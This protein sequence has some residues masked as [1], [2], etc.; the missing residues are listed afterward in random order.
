[1][2]RKKRGTKRGSHVHLEPFIE[3][4]EPELEERDRR[5]WPIGKALPMT[6]RKIRREPPPCPKCRR[7]RTDAGGQS[8]AC[9]S[10]GKDR[11]VFRCNLCN[12]RWQL[13]V[14]TVD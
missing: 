2:A 4:D 11:A 1:M 3:H 14:E 10:S 12:H 7:I 5:Y 6:Y 13:G 9:I 8:A